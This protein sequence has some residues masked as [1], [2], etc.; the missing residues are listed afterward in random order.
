M[1]RSQAEVRAGFERGLPI[2]N[3]ESKRHATGA[4]LEMF[5]SPAQSK[6]ARVAYPQQG[7]KKVRVV[8]NG[9]HARFRG[10]DKRE[11]TRAVATWQEQPHVLVGMKHGFQAHRRSERGG[12]ASSR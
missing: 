8:V 7:K 5:L 4:V 9:R 10:L 6:R 2:V 11:L 3:P 1:A 12:I